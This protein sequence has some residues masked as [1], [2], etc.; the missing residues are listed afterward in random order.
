MK[1]FYTFL[2]TLASR[3]NNANVYV[4]RPGFRVLVYKVGNRLFYSTGKG[5]IDSVSFFS[6]EK[7]RIDFV[8]YYS[9]AD[10]QKLDILNENKG[11]SGIYMWKNKNNDKF[12]IGSSNHL[13]RRLTSYFNLNYLVKESSMYINRAL[14]KEGYSSFSL[15][16]LEYCDEENLIK[17]EQYYFDLLKPTYNICTIAGSTLGRLHNEG[18]KEK[19]SESKKGTNY[20]EDNHFKGKNHTSEARD[21]MVQAKLSK[22]LSLDTREKIS[23]KMKGRMLSENHKINMSLSKQNN[24]KLSVLDLRT[25]KETIFDSINLAE[26][27][28]ELPKDS[29]RANLRSKS[30]APYRGIFKFKLLT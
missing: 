28:L 3:I 14:L 4:T 11:K 15:F 1:R 21:K 8:K 13:K 19:I 9:D 25:D 2:E 22:A 30:N 7:T 10:L 26:R 20:G 12:Y 23:V 29:I 16:I 5:K 18:V 24:K 27:C 6:K 17:R